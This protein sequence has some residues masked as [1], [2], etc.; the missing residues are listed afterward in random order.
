MRMPLAWLVCFFLG[1]TWGAAAAAEKP[2]PLRLWTSQY[3]ASKLATVDYLA[4]AFSAL[5]GG[6]EVEVT[7]FDEDDFFARL[8]KARAAGRLPHVIEAPRKLLAELDRRHMIDSTRIDAALR[9]IGADRFLPGPLAALRRPDGGGHFALPMHAWVQGI[10]YRGDWF[11]AEKLAAPQSLEAT[12][13]AARHFHRPEKGRYGIVLGTGETTYTE[14]SF[15]QIAAAF[16]ID[17]LAP[18][19][20]PLRPEGL[21]RDS[22]A[23]YRA[24][25]EYAPPPPV[26]V[27]GHRLFLDGKA[28]MVVYSSFFI[29]ALVRHD[30]GATVAADATSAG[31]PLVASEVDRITC[32]RGQRGRECHHYGELTGVAVLRGDDASWTAPVD[33]ASFLFRPDAYAT[34]LHM[35]P[36]GMLPTVKPEHLPRDMFLDLNRVY[37]TYGQSRFHALLGTPIFRSTFPSEARFAARVRADGAIPKIVAAVVDGRLSPSQ[38]ARRMLDALARLNHALASQAER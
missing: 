18:S 10:W 4:T 2:T 37:A 13:Q 30:R 15:L 33:L 5:T 24:L 22:L 35:R 32:L 38:G 19:S 12:L 20:F 23:F 6:P 9:R 3:E 16:G 29:D 21:L 1:T 26:G 34:W 27:L 8:Q 36:G 25:A 17:L 28:A 31:D 11:E 7:G 14:Q